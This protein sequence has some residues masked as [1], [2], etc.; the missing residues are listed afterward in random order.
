MAKSSFEKLINSEKPVFIDFYATWCGPC[1]AFLP[2]LKEV[3][4]EMG[5]RARIIKIDIDKNQELASKLAV[6]SVPTLM[7]YQKGAQKWRVTGGK[8]KE[9]VIAKLE[10]F[11]A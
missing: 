5:D 2:T 11:G 10:E 3:K 8:T 9:T 7:I 1:T 6:R 4:K